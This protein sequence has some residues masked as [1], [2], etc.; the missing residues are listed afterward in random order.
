MRGS[1]GI[2]VASA[3]VLWDGP[4]GLSY[5]LPR[6]SPT[7]H[8]VVPPSLQMFAAERS[9]RRFGQ[10]LCRLQCHTRFGYS[11]IVPAQHHPESRMPNPNP[12]PTLQARNNRIRYQFSCQSVPAPRHVR[13]SP[14]TRSNP[15]HF[16]PSVPRNPTRQRT[17]HRTSRPRYCTIPTG[18]YTRPGPVCV[19]RDL[20]LLDRNGDLD[21]E[22]RNPCAS[23]LPG[24]T[25]CSTTSSAS[26]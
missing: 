12:S 22:R 23:S 17:P 14:P 26:S 25:A 1:R 11:D 2:T 10:I 19:A 9:G 21:T 16:F 3:F 6:C 15:R 4:I 18:R 13:R 7:P 24:S 20:D 8:P 5:L